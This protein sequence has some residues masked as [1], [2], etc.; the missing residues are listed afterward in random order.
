MLDTKTALLVFSRPVPLVSFSLRWRT[1]LRS[2]IKL[3]NCFR[4]SWD[5]I[6]NK[7]LPG[8]WPHFNTNQLH[9]TTQPPMSIKGSLA[10]SIHTTENIHTPRRSK[11][12]QS[13]VEVPG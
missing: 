4:L 13:N 7:G 3:R 8:P 12:R 9:P 10:R 5:E 1:S 2:E 6:T 11:K